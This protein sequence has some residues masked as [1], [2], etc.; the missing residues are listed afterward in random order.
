MRIGT[1]ALAGASIAAP[2]ALAACSLVFGFDGYTGGAAVT[3]DAAADVVDA[4]GDA[5]PCMHVRWPDR[6]EAGPAGD[7]GTIVLAISYVT[8][9]GIAADGGTIPLG[10][11]LDGRCGCDRACT[12]AAR[13]T[14]YCDEP[15]SGRDDVV[16]TVFDQFRAYGVNA[17]DRD[18]DTSL[19]AGRFGYVLRI[20]RYDG[21]AN[22]PDVSV[23]FYNAVGV[24]D[25]GAPAFD[26][27]DEWMVDVGSVRGGVGYL[28][29][30]SD[31]AAYVRDGTLVAALAPQ[32]SFVVDGPTARITID[33][34]EGVLAG[35]LLR[36]PGGWALDDAQMAGRLSTKS[37][38][39]QLETLGYC[40]GSPVYESFKPQICQ[41][42]DLAATSADDG[43]P[44]APCATLSGSVGFRAGPAKLGGTAAPPDAGTRCAP[45][46]DDCAR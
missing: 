14:R 26:G 4:G 30:Y 42:A 18:L 45:S 12:N 9:D 19:A 6:P 46:S 33:F 2:L 28:P 38:L 3:P 40:A 39:S 22:D 25:G 31:D 44:G 21:E 37:V 20:D 8:I 41:A 15:G 1:I 5:D 27:N 11:D 24:K 17:R 36:V 13:K 16:K 23:A 7:G 29:I 32:M 34:A 43:R 35:R 10:F